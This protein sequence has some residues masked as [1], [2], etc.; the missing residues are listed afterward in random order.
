LFFVKGDELISTYIRECLDTGDEFDI[1]KLFMEGTD[2]KVDLLYVKF[3]PLGRQMTI[4]SACDTFLLWINSLPIPL[5]PSQLQAECLKCMDFNQALLIIEK[6]PRQNFFLF[7]YLITFL[8]EIS[9]NYIYGVDTVTLSLLFSS[10]IMQTDT[11]DQD[12]QTSKFIMIFLTEDKS[13][14]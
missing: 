2:C 1:D 6:L 3:K 11:K 5:I 9:V 8:R 13:L 10:S 7:V 4:Y 12:D 14:I